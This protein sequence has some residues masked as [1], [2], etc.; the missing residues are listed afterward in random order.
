MDHTLFLCVDGG[1]T[2]TE[3]LL[4]DTTGNILG[5]GLAGGT[6]A[7]SVGKNQATQS[8][9]KAV[10]DALHFAG[11]QSVKLLHLFIPGFSQCFPL[12]LPMAQKLSSDSANAYYGALGQPGGIVLLAGTGSFA[13]SYD[14]EGNQTS[15][16]G[17]G[18]M[19]GD[20]GSGY[21][22][23]RRAVR[24]TLRTMDE[25]RPVTP[26]G[27]AVLR[28]YD[29]SQPKDLVHAI[30]HAGCDRQQMAALCPV[31]GQ[32]ARHGDANA[33]AIMEETAE[34]LAQLAEI[35]LWR[36]NLP[37]A[38]VALIGGVSKLGHIITTPLAR[39]L[40]ALGL[41]PQRPLYTP[42]VGGVI[43]TCG[44]LT[45]SFPSPELAHRYH[46]SYLKLTKEF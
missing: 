16:G 19:L 29:V 23:G 2:K 30:Y 27:E 38:P 6:N 17:W 1:G 44:L 45:G 26:L 3:A 42:A 18:A 34:A 15:A 11:G 8:A 21:D 41:S 31:V 22:I 36:L 14:A 9:L 28:H 40:S 12:D 37:G 43:Y 4:A 25:G 39:R 13:V 46:E 35:L 5:R 7:L 33:L 24:R 32:W 20:E 10:Q